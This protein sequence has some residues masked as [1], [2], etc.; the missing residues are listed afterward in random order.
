MFNYVG[1]GPDHSSCKFERFLLMGA[2]DGIN[3]N[4]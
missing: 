2:T 4:L 3:E 1:M